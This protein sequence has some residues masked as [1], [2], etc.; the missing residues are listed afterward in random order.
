MGE[1]DEQHGL[2]D[3]RVQQAD[4]T[5]EARLLIDEDSAR[6]HGLQ[7][8]IALVEERREALCWHGDESK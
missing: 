3:F 7:P 5:G 1:G 4:A 8:R 6:P 2:A